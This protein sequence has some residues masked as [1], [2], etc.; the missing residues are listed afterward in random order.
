LF[1]PLKLLLIRSATEAEEDKTDMKNSPPRRAAMI[2][3]ML[4]VVLL[5]IGFGMNA[6]PGLH[7]I[8]WGI[9]SSTLRLPPHWMMKPNSKGRSRILCV[10]GNSVGSA[11]AKLQ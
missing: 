2:Q 8:S 5:V 11:N 1:S 9:A 3:R 7:C 6:T 4:T 10:R